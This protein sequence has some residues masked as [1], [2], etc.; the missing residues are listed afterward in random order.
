M[1]RTRRKN[2]QRVSNITNAKNIIIEYIANN[3]KSY[4]II[5]IIFFIGI[6]L[7]IMFVNNANSEQTNQIFSYLTNFIDSIKEGYKVE[8]GTLLKNSII[9]NFQITLLLW[10]LGLTV[11]GIPL[12]YCV[13]CYKGFCIGYTVSSI[14]ATIGTGKGIIFILASM[15]FQYV[16]FIPCI[17]TLAV[18]GL[19][20]DKQIMEDRRKENI[21]IQIVK[22]TLLSIFILVML[23]ISSFVETYVSG[24]LSV[25]FLKYC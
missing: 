1:E 11:I 25:I 24:N 23:L 22:H 5:T 8:E 12:I 19:K 4:L 20:V 13:I 6:I 10:F 16:I 2:I 7:G 18:S 21:K 17:L 14:I 15:L 3:A 9:K